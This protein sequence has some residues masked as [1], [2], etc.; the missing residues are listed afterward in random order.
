[1]SLTSI[2]TQFTDPHGQPAELE[3]HRAEARTKLGVEPELVSTSTGGVKN[4]A[5]GEIHVLTS[6][7][8]EAS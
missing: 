1:M 3:V 7:W 4:P 2:T 8:K 6:R 5:G